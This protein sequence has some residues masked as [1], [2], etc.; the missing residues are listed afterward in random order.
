[1]TVEVS[2]PGHGRGIR[3]LRMDYQATVRVGPPHPAL[4][5]FGI[6]FE[7]N[8]AQATHALASIFFEAVRFG[9]S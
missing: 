2:R 6:A 4:L 1:M 3:I 9:S 7:N 8:V 5:L